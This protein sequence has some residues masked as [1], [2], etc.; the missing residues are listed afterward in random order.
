MTDFTQRWVVIDLTGGATTGDGT[1]ATPD[2]LSMLAAFG[3]IG[4]NRDFSSSGYGGDYA[5]RVGS[6]PQD[7]NAGESAYFIFDVWPQDPS[8]IAAHDVDLQG[9]PYAIDAIT[10][11]QTFLGPGG[12]LTA[13]LHELEEAAHNRGINKWYD[14]DTQT[15]V[16]GETNDPVE[17]QTYPIQLPRS[18]SG[19]VTGY[20]PNFV[21]ESWFLPGSLGPFDFLTSAGMPNDNPPPGPLIKAVGSNYTI[22]RIMTVERTLDALKDTHG[23]GRLPLHRRSTAV[24]HGTSAHM[25]KKMHWSSRTRRLGVQFAA[26]LPMAVTRGSEPES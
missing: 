13:F 14:L 6:S 20:A 9:I 16:A 12:M 21:L 19:S 22:E 11:V 2:N 24:M 3:E 8:V 18:N 4:L 15:Q 26:A 10:R 23:L 5:C 25:Q 1:A 17:D 7:I